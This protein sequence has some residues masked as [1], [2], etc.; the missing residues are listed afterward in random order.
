MCHSAL[1]PCSCWP[2]STPS[3]RPVIGSA[4]DCRPGSPGLFLLLAPP[5]ALALQSKQGLAQSQTVRES[6][7]DP[8]PNEARIPH[9]SSP[10]RRVASGGDDFK[11]MGQAGEEAPRHSRGP[12]S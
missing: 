11:L 12:P 5:K 1:E 10:E 9:P 3:S 2:G 4:H 7:A 6:S 8:A